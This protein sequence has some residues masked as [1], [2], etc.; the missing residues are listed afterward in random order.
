MIDHLRT[1]LARL[2]VRYL[3]GPRSLLV[4][5][6]VC[7]GLTGGAVGIAALL[8]LVALLWA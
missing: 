4:A 5:A 1:L 7:V 2:I 6:W 8:R 3:S